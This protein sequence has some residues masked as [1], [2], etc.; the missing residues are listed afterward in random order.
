MGN[1]FWR[2]VVPYEN[3]V[4]TALQRLRARVFATGAYFKGY[5]YAEDEVPSSLDELMRRTGAR[6]HSILDVGWIA[7]LPPPVVSESQLALFDSYAAGSTDGLD[8]L[9]IP[10]GDIPLVEDGHTIFQL[11]PQELHSI[12]NTEKPTRWQLA[13]AEQ[14]RLIDG[15][16]KC[17]YIVIYEDAGRFQ[18]EQARP[19]EVLFNGSSGGGP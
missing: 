3:D 7:T 10:V 13:V 14:A 2:H 9:D 8:S 4:R 1:S 15:L 18:E 16:S 6:T 19:V 12:F 17:V 11:T 5:D